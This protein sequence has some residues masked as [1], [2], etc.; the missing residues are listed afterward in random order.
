[1]LKRCL[2]EF[3]CHF[4][5]V[6]QNFDTNVKG[7]VAKVISVVFVL[8]AQ[9]LQNAAF[10]KCMETAMEQH[11]VRCILLHDAETCFFPGYS[12]K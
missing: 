7:W 4:V 12:G 3:P 1:M 5:E 9:A 6:D 11:S 10:V 2:A 8:S